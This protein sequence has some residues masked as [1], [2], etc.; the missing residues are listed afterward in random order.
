MESAHDI[1]SQKW[2]RPIHWFLFLSILQ[3]RMGLQWKKKFF[4]QKY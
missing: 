2:L 3:T 1:R 4:L